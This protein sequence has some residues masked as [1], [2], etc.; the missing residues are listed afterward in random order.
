MFNV[1]S[2]V[3]FEKDVRQV[4]LQKGHCILVSSYAS[5]IV[6]KCCL[7]LAH[8]QNASNATFNSSL[9]LT[10]PLSWLC[11]LLPCSFITVGKRIQNQYLS[12]MRCNRCYS[13]AAI[14]SFFP[15]KLYFTSTRKV[16]ENS[17]LSWR[18]IHLDA[19]GTSNRL[20]IRNLDFITY[21]VRLSF[22]LNNSRNAIN[23]IGVCT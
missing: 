2:F 10:L 16:I 4:S 9:S 5:C 23:R 15:R 21:Y 18:W 13:T 17:L 3:R 22:R 1:F 20:W 7:Y 8:T 12:E 6:L 19:K 14:T 11:S